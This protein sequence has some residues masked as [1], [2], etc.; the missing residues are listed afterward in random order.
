MP[1]WLQMVGTGVTTTFAVH[2]GA[3]VVEAR[4]PAI[5]CINIYSHTLLKEFEVVGGHISVPQAPGLG[6]EVDWDAVE[7]YR[8]EPDFTKET[9]RQIHTIFYPDGRQMAYPGGGYRGEFLSGKLGGFLAGITAD[10]R[11]DDG[12]EEFDR[13]YRELFGA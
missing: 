3:V 5:P 6:V 1:C 4:W 8:V 13:E 11:L 9:P 2:L 12:S 10:F 7:N